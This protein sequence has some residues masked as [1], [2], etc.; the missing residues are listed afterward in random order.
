MAGRLVRMRG[1]PCVPIL[2]VDRPLAFLSGY[3]GAAFAT[4]YVLRTNMADH[5]AYNAATHAILLVLLK[6]QPRHDTRPIAAG[7]VVSSAGDLDSTGYHNYRHR[8]TAQIAMFSNKARYSS[9]SLILLIYHAL[10]RQESPRRHC[11]A[12]LRLHSLTV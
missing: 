2:W 4:A 1:C 6:L 12:L 9:T 3:D 11:L 5:H 10:R 8:Q 7:G